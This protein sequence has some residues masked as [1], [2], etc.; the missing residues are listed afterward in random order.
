MKL[1]RHGRMGSEKPAALNARAGVGDLS[2][3]LAA[4]VQPEPAE[5]LTTGTP[6]GVDRKPPTFVR[7]GD[8]MRPGVDGLG[9]RLQT[10]PIWGASLL[11]G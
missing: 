10:A 1:M 2:G 5:S 7:A 6:P 3:V 4:T 9:E 8:A 11:H